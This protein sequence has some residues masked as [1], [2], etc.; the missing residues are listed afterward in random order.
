MAPHR[1]ATKPDG[2]LVSNGKFA[3][4]SQSLKTST[5]LLKVLNRIWS[6]EE[7]HA[8]DMSLVKA[9]RR[10]L[11][12]S[13]ACIQELLQGKE[14]DRDEIGTLM[15]QVTEYK[16][17]RKK[18]QD[19]I[20]ESVKLVE[21][22]L[23][24]ELKL[25]RHS[26][27]HHN[28]L[29]K[30]LSDMKCLF[31]NALREIER[32]KKARALVEGLCDEFAKGIKEYE[33]EVRL[34]KQK[35]CEDQ[36][37]REGNDRLILHMCEAWLDER[38]QTKLRDV[39][40]YDISEK[41]SALDKL[42]VEIEA[43]L[44]A[45][46][47]DNSTRNDHKGDLENGTM[48]RSSESIHLNEPASAPWKRN[49]EDD[50][51]SIGNRYSQFCRG[52]SLKQANASM[53]QQGEISSDDRY[54]GT[55]NNTKPANKRVQSRTISDPSSS[56]RQSE[57]GSSKS[58]MQNSYDIRSPR[59]PTKGETMERSSR[60]RRIRSPSFDPSTFAGPP[61][62]VRRWTSEV[63]AAADPDISE[64]SSIRQ[65][66]IKPNTL[67]SKLME[68]RLEGQRSRARI[69]RGSSLVD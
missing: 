21:R 64:S 39:H 47:S 44:R 31:S 22:K 15:R 51:I 60:E 58:R 19:R 69:S 8:L 20:K 29:A 16:V 27:K 28:K 55:T 13:Q 33:Q 34:M 49:D 67:K 45:K 32:E 65:E 38:A 56:K 36:I 12:Q 23:E 62:P 40:G 14:R 17:S 48:S 43:F 42:C 59:M 63:L 53:R 1:P 6:L 41:H 24:H 10:E 68:A 66:S 5:E 26:E 18:E 52:A 3:Q 35:S 54:K 61:S 57:D 30:E 25:R 9:L 4:S 37:G 11:D 46:Q 7:K 2:S 50:S